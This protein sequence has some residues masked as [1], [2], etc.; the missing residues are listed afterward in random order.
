VSRLVR[1]Q[2]EKLLKGSTNLLNNA[3]ARK[4]V[5]FGDSLSDTGRLRKRARIFYPSDAYWQSRA[6]NG[7]LWI[8]YLLPRGNPR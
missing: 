3:P 4:L 8:D 1:P 2:Q 5:V 6:S 7:P